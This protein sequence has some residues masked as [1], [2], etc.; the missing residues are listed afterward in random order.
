MNKDVRVCIGQVQ[1]N[2]QSFFR[3]ARRT[4]SKVSILKWGVYGDS[5]RRDRS[6]VSILLTS[7]DPEKDGCNSL[8]SDGMNRLI[9]WLISMAHWIFSESE[10][11]TLKNGGTTPDNLGWTRNCILYTRLITDCVHL[12]VIMSSQ[13]CRKW[14]SLSPVG[15]SDFGRLYLCVPKASE[16]T[17]QAWKKGASL[18]LISSPLVLL[19]FLFVR[20]KGA[21]WRLRWN[22]RFRNY[23]M[24]PSVWSVNDQFRVFRLRSCLSLLFLRKGVKNCSILKWPPCQVFLESFGNIGHLRT[25]QSWRLQRLNPKRRL[26][27]SI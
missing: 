8:S 2:K 27:G 3:N 23:L 14:Y 12:S 19:L 1:G 10:G 26:Y 25:K 22:G 11:V 4:E 21:M 5:V 13:A 6:L 20:R 16:E 18:F 7:C 9:L 24:L 17:R 15:M